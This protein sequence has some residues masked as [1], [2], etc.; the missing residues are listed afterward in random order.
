[1]KNNNINNVVIV[2]GGTAGWM[3]ALA[4]ASVFDREQISV[5]LIESDQIASVGVGEATIPEIAAYNDLVGIDEN[6]FLSFT[7]G[8]FKLGIEFKNWGKEGDS[9]MHPFGTAGFKLSN[10]EFY[11]LWQRQFIAHADSDINDYSICHLA[12]KANKFGLPSSNPK[13]PLANLSYAYHFDA[14]KYALFLR[15]YAEKRGVKRIEGK[16]INVELHSENGNISSISLENGTTITGDLFIDCSGFKALLIEGA[17]QTG[18]DDWSHLLPCNNAVT[19][20]T[21]NTEDPI[22]YTQATAQTAGWQ[23]RIPLQN[24]VGNGHVYCDKYISKEQAIS[25]LLDNIK[26]ETIGE[27]KHIQFTTGMRKRFW[28]KNCVAIGLSSGFMEPLESTSIHLIQA[29]IFTLLNLFPADG[30]KKV[31]VDKYNQLLTDSLV[32][33]RDFLILHYH[34]NQRDDSDFWRDCRNMEIPD[35]LERKIKLYQSAGRIY[36]EGSE[37]FT[38]NGWLAVMHGQGLRAKNCHPIAN[39]YPEDKLKQ[40]LKVIKSTIEKTVSI[41]PSHMEYIKKHC[42]AK[43]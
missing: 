12:A 7:N 19:I 18:F 17:L 28:H 14:T 5:T 39:N 41:M 16:V 3:T 11:H 40:H 27:V 32:S 13:S 31:E 35:S 43:L 21:K 37:L 25:T 9:Y 30:I 24:R 42:A 20:A 29:S 15:G 6:E 26:G 2:G 22:P 33:I 8:T 38:V 4:L 1:M 10:I 36:R 23:W 34:A